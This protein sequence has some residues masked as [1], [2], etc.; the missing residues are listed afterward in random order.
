MFSKVTFFR[1]VHDDLNY[2]IVLDSLAKRLTFINSFAYELQ[3]TDAQSSQCVK[4]GKA[5]GFPGFVLKCCRHWIVLFL[6]QPLIIIA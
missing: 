1:F 4:N 3:E 2:L 6:D 5:C